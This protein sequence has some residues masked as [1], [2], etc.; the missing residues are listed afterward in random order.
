MFASALHMQSCWVVV[1]VTLQR[2]IAVCH[3]H[4]AKTWASIK[5][6]RY[7]VIAIVLFTCLF[8]W[9]IRPFQRSVYYNEVKG[10]YEAKWTDF[11]A[12]FSYRVGYMVIA[13]YLLG[14][15]IP[16]SILVFTTYKLIRSLKELHDR[17][18]GMTSSKGG[19]KDEVTISLVTVVIVFTI[20]QLTNPVSIKFSFKIQTFDQK[21]KCKERKGRSVLMQKHS[22][23]Y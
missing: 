18:V 12:S 8:Y 6:A 5:A 17:K 7:Q 13:Y 19:G 9:P 14:Y 10:R 4:Q 23:T 20:C 3:P 2:Y 21:D 22:R 11:G 16:L 1:L 15:I